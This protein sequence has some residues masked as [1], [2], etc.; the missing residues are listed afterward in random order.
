MFC[1]PIRCT[2]PTCGHRTDPFWLV[3]LIASAGSYLDKGGWIICP[4]CA[5]RGCI[6]MTYEEYQ[7]ASFGVYIT[8]I[9]R[10]NYNKGDGGG[11]LK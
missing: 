11:P 1:E 8:A 3:Q 2:D 6:D 5:S 9:I 7:D 4:K 10:P